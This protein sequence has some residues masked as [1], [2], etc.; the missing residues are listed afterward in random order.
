[1]ESGVIIT[2]S[3]FLLSDNLCNVIYRFRGRHESERKP[4][5]FTEKANVNSKSQH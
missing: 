4:E 1:M 3:E 5:N 2:S